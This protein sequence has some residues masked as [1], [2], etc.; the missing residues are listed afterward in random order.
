ML[1]AV[2]TENDGAV[3]EVAMLGDFLDDGGSVIVFPVQGVHI[4]YS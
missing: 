3:A 1:G 2:V 4:R